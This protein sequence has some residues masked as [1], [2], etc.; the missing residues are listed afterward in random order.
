MTS[1]VLRLQVF[2]KFWQWHDIFHRY[3]WDEPYNEREL[4]GNISVMCK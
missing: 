3:N 2:F 1:L 4:E